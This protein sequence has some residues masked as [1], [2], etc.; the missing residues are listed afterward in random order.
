MISNASRE[1]V[2][3]KILELA[4]FIGDDLRPGQAWRCTP[5]RWDMGLFRARI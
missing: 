5:T 1:G 2:E 3:V 4:E